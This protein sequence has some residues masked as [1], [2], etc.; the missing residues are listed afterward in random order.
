MQAA[1]GDYQSSLQ[2][3]SAYAQAWTHLRPGRGSMERV[4]SEPLPRFQPFGGGGGPS[5]HGMGHYDPSLLQV[6]LSLAQRRARSS[7][8]ARRQPR[9]CWRPAS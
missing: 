4:A 3:Q 5:E 6:G 9:L 2:F 7:E 8:Q 1:L